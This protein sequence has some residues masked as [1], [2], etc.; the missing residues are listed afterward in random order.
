MKTVANLGSLQQAQNLKL[1]LGSVGIDSFIPDEISAGVAPHFFVTRAGVRLQVD[2][3]DE[4]EAK[5]IIQE[6]SDEARA[7]K[8][9]DT[10]PQGEG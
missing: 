6:E 7:S 10:K 3:K 2:E 8:Q 5:R 4:E 9:E 1:V